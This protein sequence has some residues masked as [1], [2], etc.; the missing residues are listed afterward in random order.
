MTEVIQATA[1]LESLPDE[2]KMKIIESIDDQATVARLAAVSRRLNIG[3][4]KM[5]YTSLYLTAQ[6]EKTGCRQLRPLTWT[7]IKRPDLAK[8]VQS[9]ALHSW[10]GKWCYSPSDIAEDTSRRPFPSS[11]SS[12]SDLKKAI[13]DYTKGEA[14]YDAFVKQIQG[15]EGE[16]AI[17]T[18]LLTRL[19]LLRQLTLDL[20]YKTFWLDDLFTRW[21]AKSKNNPHPLLNMFSPWQSRST[22]H[23][24]QYLE[25][26][27]IKGPRYYMHPKWIGA[28][29]SCN[30]LKRIHFFSIGHEATDLLPYQLFLKERSSSVSE[31]ELR[32]CSLLPQELRQLVRGCKRLAAFAYEVRDS[33]VEY[34]CWDIKT[35]ESIPVVLQYAKRDLRHLSLTFPCFSSLNIPSPIFHLMTFAAFTNLQFLRISAVFLF[36]AAENRIPSWYQIYSKAVASVKKQLVK[37]IPLNLQ[38]L[39]ISECSYIFGHAVI[40]AG[41]CSFLEEAPLVGFQ[42]LD[43]YDW[44]AGSHHPWWPYKAVNPIATSAGYRGFAFWLCE[45]HYGDSLRGLGGTG[46]AWWKPRALDDGKTRRTSNCFKWSREAGQLVNAMASDWEKN[47]RKGILDRK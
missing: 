26:L 7:I 40:T 16:D 24:F 15:N 13:T 35:L 27:S 23:V 11:A 6:H 45:C 4:A 18:L 31:I 19:P 21:S 8:L 14:R 39:Q 3:A 38:R 44:D 47:V 22:N 12:D 41:I 42:E 9:F 29:L 1:T 30:K 43:L 33:P 25:E 17:L 20:P 36:D 10:L 2:L 46:E 34:G 5:L 28:G 37:A 32:H